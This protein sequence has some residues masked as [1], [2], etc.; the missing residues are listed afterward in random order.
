M[1]VL[2]AGV[3]RLAEETGGIAYDASGYAELIDRARSLDAGTHLS[4]DVS[5]TIDDFL[6]RD[7]RWARDRDPIEA[8]LGRAAAVESA[9]NAVTETSGTMPTP[10]EHLRALSN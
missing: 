4:E 3:Q 7:A 6:L 10:E 5:N 9:R 2:F 1:N 8:F